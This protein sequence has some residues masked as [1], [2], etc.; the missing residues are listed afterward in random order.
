MYVS[1]FIISDSK[2]ESL[3]S[4]NCKFSKRGEFVEW[5]D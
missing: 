4:K 1:R 3:L 2:S 5:I